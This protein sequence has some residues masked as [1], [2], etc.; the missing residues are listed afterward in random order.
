MSKFD[1]RRNVETIETSNDYPTLVQSED[2]LQLYRKQVQEEASEKL[3]KSKMSE[4]A[5]TKLRALREQSKA[6]DALSL[7][8]TSALQSVVPTEENLRKLISRCNSAASQID[9][10][11]QKLA[12]WIAAGYRLGWEIDSVAMV[13]FFSELTADDRAMSDA[14][15]TKVWNDAAARRIYASR[16][17]NRQLGE[18]APRI[19]TCK[20][21]KKCLKFANRKPALAKRAGEY[22]GSACAASNR[23]RAKRAISAA[24]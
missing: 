16:R 13:N 15:F 3:A 12:W 6:E 20:S 9:R 1:E 23:A 7:R 17:N 18:S 11:T 5:V 2:L 21:G 10:R 4:S 8:F 24:S 19:R 22:C 14:T